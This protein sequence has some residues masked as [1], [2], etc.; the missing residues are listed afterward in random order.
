MFSPSL[1]V[2]PKKDTNRHRQKQNYY[3]SPLSRSGTTAI[4]TASKPGCQIMKGRTN[5]FLVLVT[6]MTY[7]LLVSTSLIPAAVTRTTILNESNSLHQQQLRRSTNT[8]TTTSMMLFSDRR[9][10]QMEENSTTCTIDCCTTNYQQEIC[11][12]EEEDEGWIATIPVAL[13]IIFV[14]V[15][16]CLSALFSGLT[17]GL[18]SLDITGLEIVMA[19]DDPTQAQYAKNIYPIRKKGNLLLCTLIFGN[20]AVNSLLSIFMAEFTDGMIGFLTST[21]LIVIFGE[22]LPQALVR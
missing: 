9:H 15:L 11:S 7:L 1:N 19:G 5:L 6:T 20:V 2:K 10:L 13:Q 21:I 12:P 18:M 3:S 17:L 22:I 4:A 16:L 8:A 14:I